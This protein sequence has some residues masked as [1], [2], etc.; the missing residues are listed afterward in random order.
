ML[1]ECY[2]CYENFKDKKTLPCSHQFCQECIQRWLENNV[3]CPICRK[4]VVDVK[5]F[6]PDHIKSLFQNFDNLEILNWK[7]NYLGYTGYIDSI[8]TSDLNS[9]ISIGIDLYKRPFICFKGK[10]CRDETKYYLEKS[11]RAST[12]FQRYKNDE[13]TFVFANKTGNLLFNP[14]NLEDLKI[15]DDLQQK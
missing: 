6:F 12:L 10:I 9:E 4:T 5:D 7:N 3:S 13:S 15:I 11:R 2:I 14:N 1:E 8:Q